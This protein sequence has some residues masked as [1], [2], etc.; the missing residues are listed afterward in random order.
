MIII[1]KE[2][3]IYEIDCNITLNSVNSTHFWELRFF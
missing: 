1:D 3:E 2:G